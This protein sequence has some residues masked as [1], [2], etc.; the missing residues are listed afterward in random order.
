MTFDGCTFNS[1]GK[2]INVY[3]DYGA[4]KCDITVNF[5]NC[6]VKSEA[7]IKNVL[8][9]ND[10][11]MGDYKYRIHISGNNSINGSVYRDKVT[12]S[13]WFG[14]GG[15]PGNNTGRS[16]VT[17]DSTPVFE[18]GE[19]LGQRV[20]SGVYRRLQGQCL[21]GNR[22]R[23]GKGRGRYTLYQIREKGLRLLWLRC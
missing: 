8:N 22:N 7:A 4:G 15:K 19:M 3:T 10:S 20:T 21:H 9:I 1:S 23:M 6:T 13:R 14:F 18:N 16:V 17:F 2:T 5:N 12:C 11:N